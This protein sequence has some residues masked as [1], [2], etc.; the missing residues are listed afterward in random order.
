MQW[1]NELSAPIAIVEVFSLGLFSII[2]IRFDY[3]CKFF[4]L[5]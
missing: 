1:M 3:P 2:T 5:F 4:N